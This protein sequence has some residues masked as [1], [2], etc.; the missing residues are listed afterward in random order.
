MKERIKIKVEGYVDVL[1]ELSDGEI[2][3]MCCE[4][5]NILLDIA[6]WTIQR[7]EK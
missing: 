3:D 2:I 4:D 1:E 7:E 5:P 6:F